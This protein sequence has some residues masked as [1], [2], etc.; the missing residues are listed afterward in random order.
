[1]HGGH[2]S[3][4]QGVQCLACAN[5][6]VQ[7]SAFIVGGVDLALHFPAWVLEAAP[8]SFP[9]GRASVLLQRILAVYSCAVL[10][11]TQTQ[12]LV[13]CR[14][15]ARRFYRRSLERGL[16]QHRSQGAIG[17][18]F[19]FLQ[20]TRQSG[21]CCSC[22]LQGL[23]VVCAG[24][25]S[26]QQRH[27]RMCLERYFVNRTPCQSCSGCVESCLEDMFLHARVIAMARCAMREPSC[28]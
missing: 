17:N 20:R 21:V 24:Q 14:F 26:D 4:R 12:Q 27:M 15:A 13:I 8:I 28:L 2:T 6:F 10:R 23:F 7:A 11:F 9:L 22:L 19:P 3:R 25:F 5:M 1:M 18:R 16:P